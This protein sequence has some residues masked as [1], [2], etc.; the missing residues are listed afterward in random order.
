MDSQRGR[1][2][3]PHPKPTQQR[4]LSSDTSRLDHPRSQQVKTTAVDEQCQ[5][6]NDFTTID[7]QTTSAAAMPH[8][9][10]HQPNANTEA[11]SS[12]SV[13]TETGTMRQDERKTTY[14]RLDPVLR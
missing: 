2:D 10:Q 9:S 3:S 12:G 6:T 8:P 14:K 1:P 11:Q 4:P 13:T 5:Q 7:T